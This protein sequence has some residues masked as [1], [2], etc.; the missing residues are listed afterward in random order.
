MPSHV[1]W[2]LWQPRS[3]TDIIGAAASELRMT[4]IEE[5]AEIRTEVELELAR[6]QLKQLRSEQQ[7]RESGEVIGDRLGFLD[8]DA[9]FEYRSQIFTGQE[10]RLS[11]RE[12]G[13]NEPIYENEID[14]AEIRGDARLLGQAHPP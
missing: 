9:R 11:D 1:P 3:L 14:L 8:D 7:L 4:A 6:A 13:K 10:S 5:L 12:D 2:T